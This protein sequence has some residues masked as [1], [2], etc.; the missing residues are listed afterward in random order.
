MDP[1]GPL[2]SEE[3]ETL[4]ACYE[5]AMESLKLLCSRI[6]DP[7]MAE[8]CYSSGLAALNGIYLS[9]MDGSG[10][11]RQGLRQ[12]AEQV[13]QQVIA[14]GLLAPGPVPKPRVQ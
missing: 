10:I 7:E 13:A 2:T 5:S 8:R 12:I 4:T 11:S 3:I 6:D 9:A 1:T 14:G